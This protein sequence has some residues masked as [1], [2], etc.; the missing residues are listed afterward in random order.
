MLVSIGLIENS[1]SLSASL[2]SLLLELLFVMDMGDIS[3]SPNP[4]SSM[5]G[6]KTLSLFAPPPPGLLG[7]SSVLKLFESSLIFGSC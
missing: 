6:L 2:R 7:S 4:P 5:K 1:F 3:D